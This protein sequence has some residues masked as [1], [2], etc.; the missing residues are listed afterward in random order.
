MNKNQ[1]KKLKS[2][3]NGDQVNNE[4]LKSQDKFMGDSLSSKS[5]NVSI[6]P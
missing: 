3:N 2:G 1:K 6:L 4:L 5:Q